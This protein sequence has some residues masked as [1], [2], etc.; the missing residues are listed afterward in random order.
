MAQVRPKFSETQRLTGIA[1]FSALALAINFSHFSLPFPLAGYLL[2]DFWEIPIV[3]ALL[4]FGL[5][6]GITVSLVN[7]V[8]LLAIQQGSL[9]SGPFYNVA[10]TLAMFAGIIAGHK[11]MYRM[12]RNY[13]EIIAA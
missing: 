4:F 3:V 10:A 7:L 8:V 11:I 2:L 13:L 5:S 6:A 1:L 9:P 12:N